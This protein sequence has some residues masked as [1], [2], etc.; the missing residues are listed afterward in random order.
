MPP[1]PVSPSNDISDTLNT[2]ALP[3]SPHSAN[4]LPPTLAAWLPHCSEIVAAGRVRTNVSNCFGRADPIRTGPVAGTLSLRLDR[5]AQARIRPGT[6]ITAHPGKPSS[7]VTLV[8]S[9][10]PNSRV[11]KNALTCSRLCG[12][13]AVQVSPSEVMTSALAPSDLVPSMMS[14]INAT[15][16]SQVPN[17]RRKSRIWP[18]FCPSGPE[19]RRGLSGVSAPFLAY[20]PSPVQDIHAYLT[21]RRQQYRMLPRLPPLRPEP[22]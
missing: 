17:T 19:V 21:G 15:L 3:S 4:T 12:C 9:S 8:S 7:A 10:G 13:N 6:P 5:P 1:R 2:S 18:R 22:R 16:R 14:R 11:E 20:G